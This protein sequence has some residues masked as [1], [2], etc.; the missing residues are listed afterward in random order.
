MTK[1]KAY[2]EYKDSDVEWLG[3]I[4]SHWNV[5]PFF[6]VSRENRRSNRGLLE[7][8]LLS[9]SYGKIVA[10]DINTNEGL[11]PESFETYQIVEPK[12]I[13]FRLTDLQNDKRSLRSAIVPERG[14]ITSAY[15][16]VRVLNDSSRF[17]AYVMRDADLR[18]VFYSMGGGLRQSMKFDDMRRLPV[19]LPP[20]AEQRAIVSF[21]DQETAEIEA[22]VVD[23]QELIGL[24]NERRAATIT[25]AVT[26]GL[27]PNVPMKDSGVEWL[28]DVPEGWDVR[29]LKAAASLQTGVTL[30]K[31]YDDS[32]EL[33]YLRVANVQVG[34]V[35][36][37][38][39]KT[40]RVSDEVARASTLQLG[41]VLMTE[42]GDRDKLGRGCIW[43]A[44]VSPCLHQNHV[45]AVRVRHNLL[46]RFLV[47]IL[48][49][50]PA[51]TY[52]HMTGKQT[53]N[54]AATNSTLVKNFRFALPS[55]REQQEIAD[56]LDRE[57]AEIDAAIADAKEAIE[58]SKERR[59]ALISAAVTGKI[60]VRDH[61][62]AKGA[63]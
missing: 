42:G 2:P 21:L 62:A 28:G 55:L 23:Q 48:D 61:P 47:Y 51:R 16:S 37:T 6:A 29:P 34:Y 27:D 56:Y 25:Q 63:A 59:A 38:E 12:D 50:V 14:I 49:A 45:F 15:L 32:L 46:N 39:L 52:F 4:P 20:P 3:E 57:T 22:F 5:Q 9:L 11:L 33:P 24:L 19:Q 1:L 17:M 54:L 58:L 26:K 53:T 30:G 18:K 10:K 36:L 13:V 35:D 43:D 40:I 60:D 41:D 7:S 44:P 8:N 31:T